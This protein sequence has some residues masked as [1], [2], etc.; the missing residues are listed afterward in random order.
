VGQEELLEE[1]VKELNLLYFDVK[2][3]LTLDKNTFSSSLRGLELTRGDRYSYYLLETKYLRNMNEK[4]SAGLS[5]T[6]IYEGSYLF[7][8]ALSLILQFQV[9]NYFALEAKASILESFVEGVLSWKYLKTNFGWL[10]IR[11]S[12]ESDLYITNLYLKLALNY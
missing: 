5:A 8:D 10:H 6:P 7:K 9:N 2:A 4:F 3:D 11:K 12:S 1:I